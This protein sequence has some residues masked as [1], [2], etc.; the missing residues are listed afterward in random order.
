MIMNNE[1][2][3]GIFDQM[4][5]N[6]ELFSTTYTDVI[7]NEYDAMK[8]PW[9]SV[10]KILGHKHRG[11]GEDDWALCDWLEQQGFGHYHETGGWTDEDGWGLILS[12][13]EQ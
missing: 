1:D 2:V 12:R 9:D 3:Q 13:R 10:T 6:I 8:I 5:D 7:G 4:D 11:V